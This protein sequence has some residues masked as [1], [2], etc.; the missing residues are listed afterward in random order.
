[1]SDWKD[2]GM[3]NP[4][5]Q[6]KTMT[7]SITK[8]AQGN[9]LGQYQ[10]TQNDKQYASTPNTTTDTTESKTGSGLEAALGTD[11]SWD[12]KAE[13]RAGLDY[14]SQVL[15]A[16][17]Q[18]LTNRQ[19]LESQGQQMQEQVDMQK[20]SQNQSNEKAGWTGGYVLDTERQMAYL[21]Q[22]IQSQMYG[23]ME[24]Q[25]Y[26]YDTS[27]AAARL[28]YDTNKYDLAMQYYQ[29]AIENALGEAQITGYYVSPE[30]SE[31]LNE[32]SIASSIMNDATATEE[33]KRRADKVLSS[34]YNWF[35]ANGIS[36]QGVETIAH[37]EFIVALREAADKA[38]KY[39]DEKLLQIDWETFREVDENGK[40]YNNNEAS[41][42]NFTKMSNEELLSYAHRSEI[43]KQ[44]VHGYLDNIIERDIIN[45]L[46]SVKKVNDKT[47]TYDISTEDFK[48]YLENRGIVQ[49]NNILKSAESSEEDKN[50]FKS[51]QLNTMVDKSPLYISVDENGKIK[52]AFNNKNLPD[53][54]MHDSLSTKMDYSTNTAKNDNWVYSIKADGTIGDKIGYSYTDTDDLYKK[55]NNNGIRTGDQIILDTTKE[56]SEWGDK[57]NQVDFDGDTSKGEAGPY[58]EQIV[59][60]AKEG[61][62]Q[63]GQYVQFNY[64]SLKGDT[65]YTYVYIGQG[66]FAKCK[67]DA[68]YDDESTKF[69]VPTN[70]TKQHARVGWAQ[71]TYQ[72]IKKY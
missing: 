26:G 42:V 43:A 39:D 1:M 58:V 25:K 35:E 8:D 54:I 52:I 48:K 65:N 69:Y 34:V 51:Y 72:I 44:Q 15:E 7:A 62:I 30:T 56:K 14:E 16:K 46:E 5:D 59:K 13:E 53:I 3:G 28:A 21:K 66:K 11:Y 33:D 64:G 20:Y 71:R 37:Q 63:I 49:I 68:A 38:L 70:Y 23:Q 18:Y 12:T 50:L 32:Y 9:I 61:K 40:V 6:E 4:T 10:D 22:T 27:L 31:M 47:V 41:T 60:D 17:S 24:L 45:Y 29:K 2:Y 57:I 19:E 55:L 36:K 67:F